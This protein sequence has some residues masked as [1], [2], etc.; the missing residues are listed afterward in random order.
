MF[1]FLWVG[2]RNVLCRGHI[3]L[4]CSL[5]ESFC[6]TLLEAAACGL[7]VVSTS[8]GGIPEVLPH[9]MA[10]LAE[11]N[12]QDLVDKVKLAVNR[13]EAL[14]PDSL[15]ERVAS[16]YNW[17]SVAQRT[18]VVYEKVRLLLNVYFIPPLFLGLHTF[19]A[20]GTCHTTLLERCLSFRCVGSWGQFIV[21]LLEVM[22]HLFWLFMEAFDPEE[23]VER[24]VDWKTS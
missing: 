17:N 3:F 11:A 19:Q 21:I 20:M 12:I 8:V 24:A 22:L 10:L 1:C 5:T 4:N 15:Y 14:D 2:G 6:I 7:Q 16:M 18:E 13:V 23:D 9:D